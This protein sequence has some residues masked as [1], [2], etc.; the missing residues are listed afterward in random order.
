MAASYESDF[1]EWTR[2]QAFWLR[3]GDLALLDK[4]NLAEEVEHIAWRW[5][6]ELA[7]RC[8]G[9]LAHLA[10]WQRQSGHRCGLWRRLI[11]LQRTQIL[12]MLNR[13]PSLHRTVGD[14]DFVQDAWLDALMRVVGE[15]HCFDLPLACPWSLEQALAPDFFPD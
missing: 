6:D 11:D 3:S 13:A 4:Q 8:A 14:A 5:R 2:E 7:W 9:L 10:R 12:R 15:D 1:A